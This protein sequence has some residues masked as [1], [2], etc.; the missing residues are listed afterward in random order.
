MKQEWVIEIQYVEPK[1]GIFNIAKL[2]LSYAALSPGQRMQSTTNS[3]AL[4]LIH[5]PMLLSMR[6]IFLTEEMRYT[7]KLPELHL[8]VQL[9][10]AQ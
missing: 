4:S 7:C 5:L 3:A 1:A 10:Y 6:Y 9:A 8:K 2:L